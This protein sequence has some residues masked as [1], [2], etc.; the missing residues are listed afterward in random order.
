MQS[1]EG[2]ASLCDERGRVCDER[3]RE[4]EREREREKNDDDDGDSRG[5]E[6]VTV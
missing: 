3:E 1:E 6:Y 4:G 2:I 5:E